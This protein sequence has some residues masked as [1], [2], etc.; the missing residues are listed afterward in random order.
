MFPLWV[1]R[2]RMGVLNRIQASLVALEIKVPAMQAMRLR[3]LMLCEELSLPS[4]ECKVLKQ[5]VYRVKQN[6]NMEN[7]ISFKL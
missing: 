5:H 4:F 7:K 3:T 6:I 2:V 1:K